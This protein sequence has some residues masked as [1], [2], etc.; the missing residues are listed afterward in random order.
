MKS[1]LRGPLPVFVGEILHE[2]LAWSP[3]PWLTTLRPAP[4]RPSFL[5]QGLPNMQWR[6]LHDITVWLDRISMV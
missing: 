2:T 4:A 1:T 3:S 6:Q 5:F